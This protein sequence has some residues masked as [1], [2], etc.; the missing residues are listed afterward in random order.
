MSRS[1]NKVILVANAGRD[2]ET[3]YLPSGAAVTNLSVATNETWK[4]K[5]SGERQER[6]EWHRLVFFGRL[7][8]VAGEYLHKGSQLYVEGKLQTR[9]WQDK[10]TGQDRYS[11]EI[12]V[13]ELAM[14]GGDGAASNASSANKQS[15]SNSASQGRSTGPRQNWN[16]GN[17]GASGNQGWNQRQNKGQKESVAADEAE[18]PEFADVPF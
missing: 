9:K 8:E 3:R 5:E 6:V 15:R 16:K 11:T 4:D 13:S 1:V 14:L 2:P 18:D 10:N 12:V 7:A 17:Q